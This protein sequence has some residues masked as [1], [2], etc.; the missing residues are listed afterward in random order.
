MVVVGDGELVIQ[1]IENSRSGV[2]S[3]KDDVLTWSIIIMLMDYT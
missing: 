2:D 3:V 1:L